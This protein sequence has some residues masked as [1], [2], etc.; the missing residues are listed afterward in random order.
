MTP[1]SWAVYLHVLT[2][3][4]VVRLFPDSQ[5]GRRTQTCARQ[6]GSPI[7][8]VS[9]RERSCCKSC[10]KSRLLRSSRHAEVAGLDFA[11]ER[12]VF[13]HNVHVAGGPSH[14]SSREVALMGRSGDELSG[15]RRD[16]HEPRIPESGGLLLSS[17]LDRRPTHT[18]R[19]ISLLGVQTSCARKDALEGPC[20]A[21]TRAR[22]ARA[23][24]SSGEAAQ[25][26]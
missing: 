6:V 25:A 12:V 22:C 3:S 23:G 8:L 7:L 16:P 26:A 15:R 17:E 13:A 5:S 1:L 24:A 18:P 11:A 4:E 21:A 14:A 20:G 9:P 19:D 2:F 10:C